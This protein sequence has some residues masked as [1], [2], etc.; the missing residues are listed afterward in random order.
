M[1]S[2]R[3][4]GGQAVKCDTCVSNCR[5]VISENGYHYTCGLP[6][7]AANNCITGKKDHYYPDQ[8]LIEAL[9]KEGK[10]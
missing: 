3:G 7:R 10:P 6:P 1:L 2:K 4:T 8:E 5:L 9:R